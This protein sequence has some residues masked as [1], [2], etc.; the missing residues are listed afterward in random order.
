[1][2]LVSSYTRTQLLQHNLTGSCLHIFTIPS[3]THSDLLLVQGLFECLNLNPS[4]SPK[5]SLFHNKQSKISG[6]F[7]Y[8]T[9]KARLWGVPLGRT[10]LSDNYEPVTHTAL[11]CDSFRR[12]LMT[13]LLQFNRWQ[14]E[15]WRIL[16]VEYYKPSEGIAGNAVWPSQFMKVSPVFEEQNHMSHT[17]V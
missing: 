15:T 6:M 7:P 2:S 8:I 5:S 14:T 10:N 1:M 3:L 4:H 9:T 13:S 12:P 17:Y 16:E 11:T